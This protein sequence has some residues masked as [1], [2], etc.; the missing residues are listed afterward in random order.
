[1]RV[2]EKLTDRPG[3]NRHR[4]KGQG[5]PD[6]LRHFL[7][8]KI[9]DDGKKQERIHQHLDQFLP[10]DVFDVR[11]EVARDGVNRER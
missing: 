7:P 3:G 9:V 2:R 5:E 6:D 1:M 11:R 4:Q 8:V 10:R